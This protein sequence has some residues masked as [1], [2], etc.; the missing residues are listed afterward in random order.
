MSEERLILETIARCGVIMVELHHN[1][2]PKEQATTEM[3][4][5]IQA[6]AEEVKKLSL[7]IDVV[8]ERVFRPVEAELFVRYGHELGVRMNRQFLTA[9][10]GHG[11]PRR[12]TQETFLKAPASRPAHS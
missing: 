3:V 7:G 10:E 1:S 11:I 5:E 12:M 6:V 2:G 8:A 4:A 9:F